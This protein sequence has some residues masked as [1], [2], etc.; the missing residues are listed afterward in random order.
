[1]TSWPTS[2]EV[3]GARPGAA[4]GRRWPSG[5]PS[6]SPSGGTARAGD[7]VSRRVP[8]PRRAERGRQRGRASAA[9]A[10][11]ATPSRPRRAAAM[12][13]LPGNAGVTALTCENTGRPL[14][15]LPRPPALTCAVTGN[16]TGP[17][18][19]GGSDPMGLTGGQRDRSTVT[20]SADDEYCDRFPCRVYKEGYQE[21]LRGRL[22]RRATPRATRPGYAE[23]FAAGP[24]PA[25]R[26]ERP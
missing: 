10:A 22:R 9:A 21:R 12:T 4:L 1:M 26:S 16:G 18:I 17:E 3:L 25:R 14:P 13:P 23:G 20:S 15:A 5:S 7:A 6:G 11:A 2:A 19:D 8:R 24:R